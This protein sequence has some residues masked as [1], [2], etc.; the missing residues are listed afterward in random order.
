MMMMIVSTH[1]VVWRMTWDICTATRE[2]LCN[3]VRV[4]WWIAMI[5]I[6]LLGILIRPSYFLYT[7]IVL[8]NRNLNSVPL[9]L[10]LIPYGTSFPCDAG[11]IQS[12]KSIFMFPGCCPGFLNS[13]EG[14]WTGEWNHTRAVELIK[15]LDHENISLRA[16]F[17]NPLFKFKTPWIWGLVNWQCSLKSKEVNMTKNVPESGYTHA[18]NY[19]KSALFQ[20]FFSLKDENHENHSKPQWCPF[21]GLCMSYIS[22][23]DASSA[24]ASK[25]RCASHSGLAS[26]AFCCLIS[27]NFQEIQYTLAPGL[28]INFVFFLTLLISWDTKPSLKEETVAWEQV[29]RNTCCEMH[30]CS[31]SITQ[32]PLTDLLEWDPFLELPR[33][34]NRGGKVRSR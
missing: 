30:S 9:F 6:S 12:I 32:I 28:M 14:C 20:H 16:R 23:S 2:V 11:R 17:G 27:I 24:S 3:W 26:P 33:A 25:G 1:K 13:T 5:I 19:F 34:L 31:T 29:W 15:E 21:P 22:S 7:H 8:L 4:Q 10:Q 18:W